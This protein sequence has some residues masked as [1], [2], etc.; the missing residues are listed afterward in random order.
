VY[1]I[2][3][4]RKYGKGVGKCGEVGVKAGKF[5]Y[6]KGIT[7]TTMLANGLKTTKTYDMDVNFKSGLVLRS[8]MALILVILGLYLLWLVLIDRYIM[9]YDK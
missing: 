5:K 2:Q 1:N 9:L 6:R 4:E 7:Y 8:A 3:Y